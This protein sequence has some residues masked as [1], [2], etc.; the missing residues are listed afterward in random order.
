MKDEIKESKSSDYSDSGWCGETT[1]MWELT[2][3]IICEMSLFSGDIRRRVEGKS[4]SGGG[5]IK[6][7]SARIS[8]KI[9][10][11]IAI[12]GE[13]FLCL[14]TASC[15]LLDFYFWGRVEAGDKRKIV[16]AATGRQS[17]FPGHP[18]ASLYTHVSVTIAL[19]SNQHKWNFTPLAQQSGERESERNREMK[20]IA[21]HVHDKISLEKIMMISSKFAFPTWCWTQIFHDEKDRGKKNPKN[22]SQIAS[23]AMREAKMEGE[24]INIEEWDREISRHS[25]SLYLP[26]IDFY[27]AIYTDREFNSIVNS[28]NKFAFH[29]FGITE[30]KLF[31]KSL[32]R[33]R[34]NV[35]SFHRFIFLKRDW[36]FN[37]HRCYPWLFC[38]SRCY[39][40]CV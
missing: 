30:K 13:R 37:P 24:Q 21:N 18:T 25:P 34:P 16:I 23:F 15:D 20:E 40:V 14:L 29:C 36:M 6:Y 22:T 38:C 7:F 11:F 8:E 27:E 3:R 9:N 17:Q 31:L 19:V 2:M 4:M 32:S 10:C 28:W 33:H 12:V 39:L 35:R 26:N 5:T 1:V